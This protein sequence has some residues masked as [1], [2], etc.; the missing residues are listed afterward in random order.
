[1]CRQVNGFKLAMKVNVR[2]GSGRE[3]QA[4]CARARSMQVQAGSA[5]SAVIK[6]SQYTSHEIFS[7]ET[8][9]SGEGTG[10]HPE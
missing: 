4:M 3:G 7:P 10:I 2:W 1:M 8:V 5:G 9:G 6:T